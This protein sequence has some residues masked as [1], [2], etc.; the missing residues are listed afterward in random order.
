MLLQTV[1]LR[2]PSICCVTSALGFLLLL[3]LSG[4]VCPSADGKNPDAAS[5]STLSGTVRIHEGTRPWIGLALA[6]PACGIKEIELAFGKREDWIRAKSLQGCHVTATGILS[7][8]MTAYNSAE[9]N[10]FN[11][12]IAPDPSCKP[13][14]V[15]PDAIT[16]TL[17]AGLSSYRATV[18]M[19]VGNDLPLTGKVWTMGGKILLSPSWQAYVQPSLNGEKDLDLHCHEGFTLQSFSSDPPDASEIFTPGVVRLRS[20]ELGPSWLTII[21]KKN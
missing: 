16:R 2:F 7:E 21:C 17:P 20:S 9:L 1:I 14:P 12:V 4:Q 13:A 8:S 3:P 11:P 18:S 19:D 10:L 5:S 6:E 15:E